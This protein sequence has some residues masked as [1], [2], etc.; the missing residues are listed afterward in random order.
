VRAAILFKRDHS[1]ASNLLV[2]LR[3]QE[4]SGTV[5]IA[6]DSVYRSGVG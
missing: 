5:P 4:G 6:N 2:V 1:G 3:L